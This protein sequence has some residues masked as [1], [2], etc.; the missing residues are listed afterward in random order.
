MRQESFK[1]EFQN[2]VGDTCK[3]RLHADLNVKYHEGKT[4]CSCSLFSRYLLSATAS[5]IGEVGGR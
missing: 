5:A 4:K 2:L 3:D 1:Q